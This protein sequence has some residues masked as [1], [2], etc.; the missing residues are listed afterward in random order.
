MELEEVYKG[1]P[2]SFMEPPGSLIS[3]AAGRAPKIVNEAE[4]PLERGSG[5]GLNLDLN[6]DLDLGGS[7]G[8]GRGD[9]GIELMGVRGEGRSVGSSGVGVEEM[10]RRPSRPDLRDSETR[11]ISG[12]VSDL[13]MLGPVERDRWL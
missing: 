13:G 5:Q 11:F 7:R 8:G 12:R 4:W 2:R 9:E 1:P 6:L 10:P 3:S